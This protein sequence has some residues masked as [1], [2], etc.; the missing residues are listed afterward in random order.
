L[1][2]VAV[3]DIEIAYEEHGAGPPLVLLHGATSLGREDFAAQVPLFSKAFRCILPDARGHGRTRWH[4]ANATAK[5]QAS[6]FV[7]S[8]TMRSPRPTPSAAIPRA[9]AWAARSHSR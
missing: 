2:T 4:A 8:S 7:S 6:W 1:P 3:N 9:T 5:S